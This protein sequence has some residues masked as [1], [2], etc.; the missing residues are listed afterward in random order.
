MGDVVRDLGGPS[1]KVCLGQVTLF[2]CCTNV[3]INSATFHSQQGSGLDD[4]LCGHT[5]SRLIE[6]MGVSEGF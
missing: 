3:I 5:T 2:V 6:V 1:V 4:E